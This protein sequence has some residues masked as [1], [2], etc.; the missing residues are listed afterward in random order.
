MKFTGWYGPNV[1][2][3]GDHVYSDLRVRCFAV[4]ACCLLV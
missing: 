3:F 2:Y 4:F 1:L